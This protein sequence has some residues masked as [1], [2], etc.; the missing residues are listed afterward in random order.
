[1]TAF[2]ALMLLSVLAAFLAIAGSAAWV[3]YAFGCWI[4]S[5]VPK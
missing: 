2:G 5:E 3:L 4:M 1:M